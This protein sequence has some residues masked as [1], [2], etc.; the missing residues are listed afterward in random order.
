MKRKLTTE[1]AA[2]LAE[3][4]M[5]RSEKQERS[6]ALPQWAYRDPSLAVKFEREKEK[7]K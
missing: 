6:R 1:E 7:K 3:I 5:Q 2:L 4:A